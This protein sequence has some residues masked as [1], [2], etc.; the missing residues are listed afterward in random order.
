M[1]DVTIVIREHELIVDAVLATLPRSMLEAPT[2]QEKCH[3]HSHPWTG[4]V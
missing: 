2:P 3:S 1:E 4:Q